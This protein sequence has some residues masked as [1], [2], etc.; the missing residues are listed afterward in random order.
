MQTEDK[1]AK[2]FPRG[3]KLKKSLH[4]EPY[5]SKC[6]ELFI[7]LDDKKAAGN[8]CSARVCQVKL[9]RQN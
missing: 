1:E 6:F 4:S 8:G 5:M 2:S 7:L 9:E 3:Q